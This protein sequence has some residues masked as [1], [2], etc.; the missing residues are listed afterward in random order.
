[1][2]RELVKPGAMQVPG[3][4]PMAVRAGPCVFFSTL[5]GTHPE[6]GALL[7]GKDDLSA[8]ARDTLTGGRQVHPME[9]EVVAQTWGIFKNFE[10]GLRPFGGTLDHLVRTNTFF[11]HYYDFVAF[12][13]T[14]ATFLKKAP[15]ASSVMETAWRN[16]DPRLRVLMHGWAMLPGADD[17]FVKEAVTSKN[18]A[19]AAAHFSLA[20]KSGPLIW[21]AGQ[22]GKH[23]KTEDYIEHWSEL[24]VDV[25]WLK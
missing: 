21:P 3:T 2:L 7:R 23:P 5:A 12:E 20:L 19:A 22:T 25:P 17:L 16:V 1:M 9:W 24:P 15:P 13:R 14:R 10:Q 6:T 4:S 11:G 8:E 18:V